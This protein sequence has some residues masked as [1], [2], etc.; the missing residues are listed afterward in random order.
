MVLEIL[1]TFLKFRSRDRVEASQTTGTQD[2]PH[3]NPS[4]SKPQNSKPPNPEAQNPSQ[5]HPIEPL[6]GILLEV[7]ENPCN[8]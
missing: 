1:Y 5:Q 7:V 3:Q 2:K 4:P 6:L 8:P